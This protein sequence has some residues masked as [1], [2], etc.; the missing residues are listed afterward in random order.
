[1]DHHDRREPAKRGRLAKTFQ[2]RFRSRTRRQS[3]S[4]VSRRPDICGSGGLFRSLSENTAECRPRLEH[5]WLRL[6]QRYLTPGN[7]GS[8]RRL[9]HKRP[10]RSPLLEVFAFRCH[11]NRTAPEGSGAIRLMLFFYIYGHLIRCGDR[12]SSRLTNKHP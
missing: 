3:C 9:R 10:R 5:R 6:P 8:L 7:E 11:P 4:A 2:S 1:M 12:A